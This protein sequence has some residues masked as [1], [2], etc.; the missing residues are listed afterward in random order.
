MN[1]SRKLLFTMA[2]CDVSPRRCE[3]RASRLLLF[4]LVIVSS[5]LIN[6]CGFKV[7]QG[8]NTNSGTPTAG[9]YYVIGRYYCVD[10]SS[11]RDSGTCDLESRV[12]TSCD[13]A[14]RD[15]EQVLASRGD[16]C[17]RCLANQTDNT[18]RY[19]GKHEF[20]QGGPCQVTGSSVW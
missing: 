19:N 6:S 11:G 2:M 7:E 9:E 18:K 13:D 20:I 16:I 17:Q 12:K 10:A 1:T 3:V 5:V 14:L 15:Q 8:P 4:A